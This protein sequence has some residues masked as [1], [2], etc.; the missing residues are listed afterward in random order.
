[1]QIIPLFFTNIMYNNSYK[2]KIIAQ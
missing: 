2:K 1:M